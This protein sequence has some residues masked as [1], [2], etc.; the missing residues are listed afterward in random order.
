M[1]ALQP[2]L[3]WCCPWSPCRDFTGLVE[4]LPCWAGSTQLL[5]LQGNTLKEV[6]S[7]CVPATRQPCKKSGLPVCMGISSKWLEPKVH[8]NIIS[9]ALIALA[10]YNVKQRLPITLWWKRGSSEAA[11]WAKWRWCSIWKQTASACDLRHTASTC[12]RTYTWSHSVQLCLQSQHRESAVGISFPHREFL[13]L[14][15][16]TTGEATER[17][18]CKKSQNNFFLL[19]GLS[20]T[21]E[22]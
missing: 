12:H 6:K 17:P 19:F 3:A 2:V 16:F 22:H 11:C 10:I 20:Q 9:L 14:E 4:S 5:H 8:M 15:S 18:F 21:I 1:E 13:H 7:K